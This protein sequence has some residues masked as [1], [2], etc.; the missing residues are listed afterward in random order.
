MPSATITHWEPDDERFWESTGK[1]V[2][3]RNLSWSIFAEFLGFS[4]W[5][6]WSVVAV[7]LNDVGFS[8]T[9]SQLFWLVSG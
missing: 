1:R 7:K 6:L 9:T 5:Q 2:A 3:R 8:L 4:I